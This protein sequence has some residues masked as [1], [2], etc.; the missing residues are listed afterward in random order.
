MRSRAKATSTAHSPI[1][2]NSKL[3]QM[4]KLLQ[5]TKGATIED[6]TDATGWQAH[7]VRG[8]ISGSLRK[9]HCLAITTAI[10]DKRGRVYRL[11]KTSTVGGKQ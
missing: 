10:D 6:L 7:S 11:P 9:K 1:L 2:A 4:I 3:G 8:A 5:R